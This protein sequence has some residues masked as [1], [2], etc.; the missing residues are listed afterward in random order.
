MGTSKFEGQ[1]L[2][3][4][5]RLDAYASQSLKQNSSIKKNFRS[6]SVWRIGRKIM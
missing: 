5:V 1:D 6:F 2:S 4:N 3:R